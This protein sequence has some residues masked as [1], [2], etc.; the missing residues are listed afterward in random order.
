MLVL[1][2]HGIGHLHRYAP[3][4][5]LQR[6]VFNLQKTHSIP[7]TEQHVTVEC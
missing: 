1:W 5:S 6:E 3:V 7:K 2:Y 4:E